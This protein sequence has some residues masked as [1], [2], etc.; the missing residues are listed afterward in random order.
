MADERVT[1]AWKAYWSERRTVQP[2]LD[3]LS[4]RVFQEISAACGSP[5]GLRILEAGSGSGVISAAIAGAGGKVCLLD[6]AQDALHVARSYFTSR[7][8]DA[9][10]VQ[11]DIFSLPF[12]PG[13]FSVV[14]NSGV[15]EHFTESEQV[16]IL[17]SVARILKKDGFLVTC[18]P[19][20][21]A[22]FYRLGKK[23]AEDKGIWPY[24]PEYPVQSLRTICEAT[25]FTSVREY[26]IC[27]RENLSFYS[28]VSRPA[29]RILKR[30][31]MPF[32]ESFLIRHFGGYLL[33]TTAR[34]K[35]KHSP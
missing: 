24:G 3:E 8:L 30:V 14:W 9:D 35:E 31:F 19:F 12:S 23:A 34:K 27:F 16:N 33:V 26:P 22:F 13:Q 7:G 28:Y 11:A 6:I 29:W 25:G 20:Q 17:S 32:P 5:N 1:G 2:E 4:L 21:G 15:M 18:N 10:F